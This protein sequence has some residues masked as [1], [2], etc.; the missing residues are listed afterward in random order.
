M[1]AR[2]GLSLGPELAL[3]A[4]VAGVDEVGRGPWAGPVVAA[5]VILD[6]ANVPEGLR[7]SKA[8]PE[9]RRDALAEAIEA[10]A[11][12]GLGIVE[13][14]EI[15]HVGIGAAT[16]RA[17]TLAVDALGIKPAHLLVDGNRLP[18]WRW[19]ATA[20]VRGDATVASIAAASLVAKAARDR[21]MRAHAEADPRYGWAANKGYGTAEHAVALARF[22]PTPLHR[23]SFRPVAATAIDKANG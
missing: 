3:P 6:P 23:M 1:A 22:G 17:M 7:D 12:V 8:V 13:A 5:A 16:D 21:I 10:A 14:D 4:P 19:P 9:R 11:R 20:I 15:D 2:R 18:R